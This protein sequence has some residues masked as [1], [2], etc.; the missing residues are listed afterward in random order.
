MPSQT[1]SPTIK[2][3]L[4]LQLQSEEERQPGE[5]RCPTWR[6]G[7]GGECH[8]TIFYVGISSSYTGLSVDDSLVPTVF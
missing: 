3:T 4:K 8:H 6:R 7:G 2:L 5:M 1:I